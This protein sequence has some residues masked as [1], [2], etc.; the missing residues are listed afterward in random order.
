MPACA[1]YGENLTRMASKNHDQYLFCELRFWGD[2]FAPLD[3][4][5]SLGGVLGAAAPCMQVLVCHLPLGA[6]TRRVEQSSLQRQHSPRSKA[7]TPVTPTHR[8]PRRDHQ[9]FPWSRRL[10]PCRRRLQN[11]FGRRKSYRNRSPQCPDC[12]PATRSRAP[13]G[14]PK[15]RHR[16]D[17]AGYRSRICL[18]KRRNTN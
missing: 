16:Q 13:N 1:M 11:R 3:E 5:W 6:P 15:A 9:L 14:A 8:R 4:C 18:N 10:R 17:R 2:A 12:C 7:A